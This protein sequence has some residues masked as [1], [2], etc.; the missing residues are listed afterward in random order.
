MLD[1]DNDG[2]K[3]TWETMIAMTTAF[4]FQVG[5]IDSY[6]IPNSVGYLYE[7][8]RCR[9]LEQTVVGTVDNLDWSFDNGSDPA[10]T[11]QGKQWQ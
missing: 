7:E 1:T 5:V 8:D 6:G 10:G 4:N 9:T 3:D 11:F 2:Y